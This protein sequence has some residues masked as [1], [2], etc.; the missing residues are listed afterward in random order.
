[1]ETVPCISMGGL[2]YFMNL[3]SLLYHNQYEYTHFNFVLPSTALDE[4][5]LYG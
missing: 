2:Y 1:M 4:D 3:P 5:K